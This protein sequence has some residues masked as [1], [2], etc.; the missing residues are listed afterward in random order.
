MI[1]VGDSLYFSQIPN[2]NGWVNAIVNGEV[3]FS[4]TLEDQRRYVEPVVSRLDLS[5]GEV[6]P[7]GTNLGQFTPIVQ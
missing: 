5:S 6:T 2:L 7:I 4:G 1:A 3:D